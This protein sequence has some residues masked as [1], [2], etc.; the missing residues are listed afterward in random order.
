MPP[1]DRGGVHS[2][3]LPGLPES[4]QPRAA[5]S[6]RGLVAPTPP[7]RDA[8]EASELFCDDL[9]QDVPVQT[10]IGHQA[11][12][13]AVLITELPQLSQ[14]VQPEPRILLLPKI[15]ALLTDAMLAANLD[16]GRPGFSFPKRPQ[17][18]LFSVP[19]LAHP[20]CLLVS[21]D[22]H[23]GREPSASNRLSFWVLG[24]IDYSDM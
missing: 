5:G 15:N 19:S 4:A 2:V 3:E 18:L 16:H 7:A 23:G 20:D 13:L 1:A 12:Q 10:Q 17:N 14:F 24:Q 9:L 21:S 6:N 22:N 8:C 11:L